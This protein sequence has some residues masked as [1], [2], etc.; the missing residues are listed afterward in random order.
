MIDNEI[1]IFMKK[2][3]NRFYDGA[4]KLNVCIK[5]ENVFKL[6]NQPRLYY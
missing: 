4:K 3:E 6:L 2:H 5:G 1:R